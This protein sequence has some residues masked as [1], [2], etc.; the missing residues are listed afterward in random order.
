MAAVVP[1]KP[2]VAVVD[3]LES[4]PLVLR[5]CPAADKVTLLA[6][7]LIVFT[8]VVV[9]AVILPVSATLSVLLAAPIVP[10]PATER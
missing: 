9:C 2:R 10:P 6:P 7:M 1:A 4:S 5:I 3:P 8:V